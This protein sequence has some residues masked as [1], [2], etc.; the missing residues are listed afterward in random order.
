MSNLTSDFSSALYNSLP[1]VEQADKDLMGCG[2]TKT[3]NSLTTLI[4]KSGLH[5]SI[6]IRLLHSHNLL[7]DDELMIES[8]E[9]GESNTWV[10]TTI[11]TKRRPSQP[12]NATVWKLSDAGFV[13]LEFS[14][15]PLVST[16]CDLKDRQDFFD[17][18]AELLRLDNAAE[19]LGPCVIRREFYRRRRPTG[20]SILVE[21]SD[22]ERRA[23]ILRFAD[24]NDF[25]AHRLIDT[26]WLA[27]TYRRDDINDQDCD[28]KCDS[29]CA[30]SG[31]VP[32]TACVV[33]PSGTHSS[34][35]GHTK[36]NHV[37]QHAINHV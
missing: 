11:A 16:F 15:D 33:D 9:Y 25:A 37:T 31:C 20:S 7:V 14:V 19:V 1:C 32:V 26:T 18:F 23:N 17:N 4:I 30:A 36:G 5:N 28:T 8:E 2:K 12:L 10:L 3:L 24:P 35:T 22:P 27:T 6:G 21:T 34:Q 29:S 13:P